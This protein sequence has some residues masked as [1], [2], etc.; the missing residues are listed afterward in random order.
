MTNRVKYKPHTKGWMSQPFGVNKALY[1]PLG[2]PGGHH[3]IDTVNGW[4]KPVIADNPGLIYKVRQ[5]EVT[6]ASDVF[7]LVHVSDNFYVEIGTAHYS[8]ILVKQGEY[9]PE[10]TRLGDEGNRGIVFSGGRRITPEEQD[11]GN[12]AGTHLHTQYRPV[13]AVRVQI[14]GR[15]YLRNNDG[16]AYRDDKGLVYEILHNDNGFKGCVDPL[17]YTY[18]NT[19]V[20]DIKAMSTFMSWWVKR[21]IPTR[22]VAK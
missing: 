19:M 7:Q 16:T 9:V 5:N 8:R 17:Q 18:K 1:A 14:K 11:A 6:N 13:Q 4:G 15:H 21:A 20:E 12:K 3:G 10:L 2:Y 22:T